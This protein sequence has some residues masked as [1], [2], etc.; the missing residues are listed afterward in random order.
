MNMG[1]KN[2]TRQWLWFIFLWCM[3]LIAVIAIAY[4]IKLLIKLAVT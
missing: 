1:I 3:G 2:K 4:P